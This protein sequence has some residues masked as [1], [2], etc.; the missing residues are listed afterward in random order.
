MP[1]NS[2]VVHH[3]IVFQRPPDGTYLKG[4][5]MLAGYVPGQITSELP[6]GYAYRIAAGAHLVFQM[7]YTPNGKCQE[8]LT[9]LGLVFAKATDVT[10]EVYV[11]NG[12][13]TEFE[14]P[15]GAANHQVVG[16]VDW[17][18]KDGEILSLTPHMHVRGKSLAVTIHTK[19]GPSPL[20]RVPSYDFNWQHDYDLANPLPLQNV[21]K[22]SFTATFD[23]SDANPNNPD[24]TQYV[25]W[26]DQ[27]WEE[28]ALTFLRVAEPLDRS[29]RYDGRSKANEQNEVEQ[30]LKRK[31]ALDFADKYIARFD[32]N[33]DQL[34]SPHEVPKAVRAF[35]F[36]SYDH[37]GDGYLTREEMAKNALERYEAAASAQSAL[38]EGKRKL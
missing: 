34:L 32:D 20:L 31:L 12:I 10:H 33:G 29:E 26:G 5:G 2:A 17:F 23:N 25:G 15:P 19:E 38:S 13:D 30:E 21:N 3:C 14:I 9:R 8:D 24:P 11:I 18:P 36:Y 37:D 6:D 22:I 27:T 7:H 16:D 35:R 28:M 4:A 1:G